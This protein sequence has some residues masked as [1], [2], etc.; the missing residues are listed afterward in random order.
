MARRRPGKHMGSKWEFP[1]G[2]IDPGESP[3]ECLERELKEEFSV[4]ARIGELIGSVQFTNLDVCLQ[5]L[6]YRVQVNGDF[7]LNEHEVIRWV[8]PDSILDYDLVD[9]DRVVARE[10]LKP[11]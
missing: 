11:S 4:D 6:V 2:K 5:I 3:E 10:L 1:G 7:I 8:G 9:S